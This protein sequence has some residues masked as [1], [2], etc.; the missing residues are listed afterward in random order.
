MLE[1]PRKL[2]PRRAS[3]AKFCRKAIR[4]TVLDDS[5]QAVLKILEGPRDVEALRRIAELLPGRAGSSYSPH[6]MN[7]RARRRIVQVIRAFHDFALGEPRLALEVVVEGQVEVVL[8]VLP[9]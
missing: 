4:K 9:Q 2:D 5:Q 8:P 1:K 6:E 3:V 7:E